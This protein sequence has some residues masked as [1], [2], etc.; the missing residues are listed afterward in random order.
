[1]ASQRAAQTVESTYPAVS[2]LLLSSRLLPTT[3]TLE[4]ARLMI[5][6][7]GPRESAYTLSALGARTE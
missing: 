3:L 4:R 5:I 7:L 2:R 6:E 1:M